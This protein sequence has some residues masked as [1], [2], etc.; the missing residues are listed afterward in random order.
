MK[1]TIEGYEDHDS[2]TAE[3]YEPILS[4]SGVI[5][6][7]VTPRYRTGSN[8]FVISQNNAETYELI[9]ASE[10]VIGVQYTVYIKPLECDGCDTPKANLKD[11]V[12]SRR[13]VA[14][15]TMKYRFKYGIK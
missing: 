4:E 14:K 8:V 13:Q 1:L 11:Y 15:E 5:E 12:V 2:G 9:G 6:R 10:L 7:D 3:I